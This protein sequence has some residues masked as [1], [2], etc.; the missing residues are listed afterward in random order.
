MEASKRSSYEIVE[1]AQA[2]VWSIR[3]SIIMTITAVIIA[4]SVS[5]Q[6]IRLTTLQLRYPRF[7]HSEFMTHRV[8]S[9][10]ASSSRAI[11]VGRLI[12]DV[13]DDPVYPSF[14]GRNQ[15]GMQADAE[16]GNDVRVGSV[17][18]TREGAWD[19]ARQEAIWYARAFTAAGYH[20]QI[21]NRLLEPFCHINVVVT[22]TEWGNFFALRCH[23]D[24][25]PEM[26][27]LAE[28]MHAAMSSSDPRLLRPGE[29]HLPYCADVHGKPIGLPGE[30]NSDDAIKA[31]V[32]RCARVSYLTQD[33]R[34]PTIEED[35]ALYDRLVASV[36]LHASPSEHQATPDENVGNEVGG[37]IWSHPR[38][39]GNFRGWI[40]YRKTL[41][42]ESCPACP[43][44]GSTGFLPSRL[45]I[46]VCEFCDGT[47]GGNPPTD[48]EVL[49]ARAV[50]E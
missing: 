11:P 20:K 50:R 21:V 12:R 18:F 19:R 17:R 31:S 37:D 44:C 22:A 6:G 28:A 40:Q 30:F 43:T 23:P 39:H 27:L 35:L 8:F 42:N 41:P 46:G 13:I 32:A 16:C 9:R 1:D 3:E 34:Q 5:S 47:E 45:G 38:L 33:G 15:P 25:Q 14:W 48:A 49:E 7:I 36:P 2:K 4:D 29:W 10:N 26:R 24:A